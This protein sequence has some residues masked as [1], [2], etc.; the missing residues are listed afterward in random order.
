MSEFAARSVQFVWFVTDAAKLDA[1]NLFANLLGTE[2]DSVNKNR[3]PSPVAPYLTMAK[4]SDG[5]QSS[6]LSV[7]PGRIDLVVQPEQQQDMSVGRPAELDARQV[8]LATLDRIE[9]QAAFS[10]DGV[11]RIAVVCNYLEVFDAYAGAKSAFFSKIGLTEVE[12]DVSDLA[13]QINKRFA[14]EELNLSA[15]RL[16]GTTIDLMQQLQVLGG[17]PALDFLSSGRIVKEF[18][19]LNT[20]VDVNNVPVAGREL[21]ANEVLLGM[22][23]FVDE[24]LRVRQL[25]SVGEL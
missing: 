20:N 3:I 5:E 2:P 15:N 8:M 19:I 6:T 7:S 21:A 23:R 17:S 18:F 10:V 11:Y 25:S 9:S 16:L 12:G 24:N 1:G 22:R 14:F 4:R 13:F